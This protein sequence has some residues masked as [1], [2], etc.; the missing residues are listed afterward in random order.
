M[1]L[2][3]RVCSVIALIHAAI[4][5]AFCQTPIPGKY[6]EYYTGARTGGSFTD[7]GSGGGPSINDAREVAFRGATASGNGLWLGTGATPPVNFNPGE[8]FASSDI[9]NP[10]VQ[11][12]ANRQVVSQDRITTT[13]PATTA[14]RLYN[15]GA[16]DS[17]SYAAR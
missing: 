15:G 9:I 16:T 10:S 6:Y 8:S 2:A 14:V 3:Y 11:V 4:L 17:F 13:S 5:P 7:L 12:S 1:R